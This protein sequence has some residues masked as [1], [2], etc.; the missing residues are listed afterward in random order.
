MENKF[1][2]PDLKQEALDYFDSITENGK[3]AFSY[4]K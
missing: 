1:N 3:I 4:F 2:F